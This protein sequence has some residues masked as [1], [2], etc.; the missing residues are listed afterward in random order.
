M[1]KTWV[2]CGV[3][4]EELVEIFTDVV[5]EIASRI[6]LQDVARCVKY[7]HPAVTEE[8]WNIIMKDNQ[9]IPDIRDMDVLD[10]YLEEMDFK[11]M[12]WESIKAAIGNN[13][14]V[15]ESENEE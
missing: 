4:T 11:G 12:I 6:D 8:Q 1:E 3:E 14:D 2:D 10:K 15:N 13:S 7:K 9:D 5:R